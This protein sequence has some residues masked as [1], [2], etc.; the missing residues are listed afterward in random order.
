MVATVTRMHG[1]IARDGREP[2]T[3]DDEERIP[4]GADLERYVRELAEFVGLDEADATA[5]RASAPAILKHEAV[6]TSALY[7]HFLRFPATARFFLA[8][9][10]TPDRTRIDRRKHSL[11]RW[12][13]ETAQAALTH[14]FA[15][16]LL[17][18]GLA[19][20]H[21]EH[22]PGGKIPPQFMVAA[23]SLT[24]TALARIFRDELGDPAAALEAAVAW[25][26]L[27]LLHLNVLLIGY[28]L[29]P[30]KAS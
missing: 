12:L 9:D 2:M 8:P 5:I 14:D 24:Q 13:R 23:M 6:L 29:P 4:P 26:K 21:R 11:A 18:V 20:S 16:Y 19:H 30:R 25:N 1:I 3:G 27:L 22:G 15:Y 10:G 17:S 28:L 7:E